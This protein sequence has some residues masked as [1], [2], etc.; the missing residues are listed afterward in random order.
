M[1]PQWPSWWVCPPRS[2]WNSPILWDHNK[3]LQGFQGQT[4]IKVGEGWYR[5]MKN[6]MCIHSDSPMSMCTLLELSGIVQYCEIMTKWFTRIQGQTIIKV[7]GEG[8]R[9]MKYKRCIQYIHKDHPNECTLQ[10]L[11]G[12]VQCEIMTKCYKWIKGQTIIKV[13]EGGTRFMKNIRCV[14]TVTLLMNAPS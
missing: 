14:F 9:F 8:T 11:S 10:E 13:G 4:I 5:F 3:M 1:Y 6:Q 2:E 7:G 12:I